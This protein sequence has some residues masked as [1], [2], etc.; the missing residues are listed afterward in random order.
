MRTT[1]SWQTA[2][3]P[4]PKRAFVVS[5]TKVVSSMI[6]R[7]ERPLLVVGHESLG[8]VL[9]KRIIDYAISMA[10]AGE[11]PVVATA[12]IIGEFKERGYEPAAS[13]SLIEI[14]DRLRDPNWKGIS[15]EGQYDLVLM[16]GFPY[17]MSWLVLSGLKHFALRGDKYL[18]TISLD[19]YYQPNASWS[20]LN[21]S[22]EEWK[23]TILSVIGELEG[24]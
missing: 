20:L 4:G 7:A 13:M 18:T 24:K 2:E 3:I 22:K 1:E 6:K 15:G 17:Y 5:K 9:E 14:G 11:I 12:H 23:E 10:E 16:M 19:R 21:I 8:E